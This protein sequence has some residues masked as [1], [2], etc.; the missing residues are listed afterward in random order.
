MRGTRNELINALKDMMN[1]DATSDINA[2]NE[3]VK[4]FIDY[5]GETYDMEEYEVKK[6]CGLI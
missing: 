3:F 2:F 5:M 1:G 6:N 4:D